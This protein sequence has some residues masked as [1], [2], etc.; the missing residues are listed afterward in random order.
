M[1]APAGPRPPPFPALF[2]LAQ[3]RWAR[4]LE[5]PVPADPSEK[6]AS[7]AERQAQDRRLAQEASHHT[8]GSSGPAGAARETERRAG[9]RGGESLGG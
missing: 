4:S 3:A 5:G 2:S 7:F 1:P 8:L 6:A 9:D